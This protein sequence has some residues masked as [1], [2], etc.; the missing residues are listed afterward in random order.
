MGNGM[1]GWFKTFKT[2]KWFK[3]LTA[4]AP[5]HDLGKSTRKRSRWC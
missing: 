3:S 5:G 4:K 1:K 2:F